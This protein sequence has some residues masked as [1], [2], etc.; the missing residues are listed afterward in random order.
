[1][2]RTKQT[3]IDALKSTDT[4]TIRDRVYKMLKD[5]PRTSDEISAETGMV[6]QTVGPRVT[7]LQERGLVTDSHIRRRTRSGKKAIVWT[8]IPNSPERQVW[9]GTLFEPNLEDGFRLLHEGALALAIV[10]RNGIRIDMDYAEA[11]NLQ[12]KRKMEEMEWELKSSKL[13][14]RMAS[15]AKKQNKS[16]S[17]TKDDILREVLFKRMKL[18]PPKGTS[19]GKGSVDEDALQILRKKVPDLGLL[20]R[21]RKL[22]K[23]RNTYFAQ[24]L[25]ETVNGYLH[26]TFNLH[27][28]VSYRSSS[29]DPNFQN[30]PTRDP[31]TKELIRRAFVPRAGHHLLE[32]DFSGAEVVTSCWYH[33]DPNMMAYVLDANKDMHRDMAMKIFKVPKKE[34]TKAIRHAGKNQFVFPNFYGSYYE[35]TAPELWK[36]ALELKTKSGIPLVSWLESKGIEDYETFERNVKRVED[37]FWNTM[38]PVYKQWKEDIWQHYLK[39]GWVGLLSGFECTDITIKRNEVINRPIQGTAFHCLLWSL[40]EMQ[41]EIDKRELKTKIIGQIHDSLVMDVPENELQLVLNLAKHIFTRKIRKHWPW[42]IV[43]L[44][45]EPE[46]TPV[47]EAWFFKKPMEQNNEGIWVWKEAA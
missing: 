38:F 4:K 32:Y 27:I 17:F 8:T 2:S 28:P 24:I 11:T 47:D 23:L 3:S 46:V 42:I 16:L 43:P 34:M 10:E 44:D 1:M 19:A 26:P 29:N 9:D 18:K 21:W 35:Q 22:N 33:K 37:W 15:E 5:K 39:T 20:L 7:E 6:I 25:R 31:E 45:A 36:S 12:L 41:K 40:V 30:I 14:K 13:G